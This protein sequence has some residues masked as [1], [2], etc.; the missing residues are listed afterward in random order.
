MIE[1]WKD[2]IGYEGFYKISNF[3]NV[4]SC[5]R[6]VA[7]T[8]LGSKTLR[9]RNLRLTVD[10]AGYAKVGLYK[11]SIKEV[12]KVHRLVALHFCDKSEGC[13]IVNH[14]DN[15]TQNNSSTNLEW[16]TSLGNNQHMVRQ[17]RNRNARG[18]D[19]SFSELTDDNVRDIRRLCSLKVPQTEIADKYNISQQQ[20]SKINLR[21]RWAHLELDNRRRTVVDIPHQLTYHLNHTEGGKAKKPS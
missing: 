15:D 2:I 21:L 7:D 6:V 12:W 19:C 18:S 10:S 8:R 11:D 1:V 9:Q 17:G 4:I 13:D 16:T 5:T 3:G 14:L 20:V